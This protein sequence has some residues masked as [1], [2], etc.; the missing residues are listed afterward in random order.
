MYTYSKL[1][2]HLTQHKSDK[3]DTND[4]KKACFMSAEDPNGSLMRP[5]PRHTSQAR[6]SFLLVCTASVRQASTEC[7]GSLSAVEV[8]NGHRTDLSLPP[9]PNGIW[10]QLKSNPRS[11]AYNSWCISSFRAQ[12]IRYL[13]LK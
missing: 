9:G 6:P 1:F 2:N 4:K 12:T 5:R 10:A 3:V 11:S 13:N 7:L 8:W